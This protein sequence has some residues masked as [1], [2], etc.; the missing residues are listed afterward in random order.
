MSNTKRNNHYA[1]TITNYSPIHEICINNKQKPTKSKCIDRVY[2]CTTTFK[3]FGTASIY[4][5][6]NRYSLQVIYVK[7]T[8]KY[9]VFKIDKL[10][11]PYHHK[12]LHARLIGM[13]TSEQAMEYILSKLDEYKDIDNYRHEHLPFL[14]SANDAIESIVPTLSPHRRLKALAKLHDIVVNGCHS[15]FIA[16]EYDKSTNSIQTRSRLIDGL[17]KALLSLLGTFI[18]REIISSTTSEE[19]HGIEEYFYYKAFQLDLSY[20][21]IDGYKNTSTATSDDAFNQIIRRLRQRKEDEYKF[22]EA[23]IDTW[24]VTGE[25]RRGTAINLAAFMAQRAIRKGFAN[26]KDLDIIEDY[27]SYCSI[28]HR[29]TKVFEDNFSVKYADGSNILIPVNAESIS[30]K[31]AKKRL[32]QLAETTSW[33]AMAY[34]CYTQLM[35]I[36]KLGK[37]AYCINKIRR[38]A[39]EEDL[40]F[41]NRDCSPMEKYSRL[42]IILPPIII[43][44]TICVI[45]LLLFTYRFFTDAEFMNTIQLIPYK[46][47]TVII[48]FGIIG[49]FFWGIGNADGYPVYW[50]GYYPGYWRHRRY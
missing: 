45:A 15:P 1:G 29:T 39:K 16:P 34:T 33:K 9:A 43:T 21:S 12:T 31:D 28:I 23:P 26:D 6:V 30:V 24:N 40:T 22:F 8:G 35:L 48:G 44:L 17:D 25:F 38:M 42:A 18:A 20:G 49:L 19:I 7:S 32:D 46:I 13:L 36:E 4:G 5:I 14:L 47:I 11:D 41:T 3:D 2:R 27:K 10:E 37:A 50:G